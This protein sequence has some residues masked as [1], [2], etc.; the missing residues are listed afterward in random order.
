MGC[1]T[2]ATV[3]L[4]VLLLLLLLLVVVVVVVVVSVPPALHLTPRSCSA[5]HVQR[6]AHRRRP[7]LQPPSA[8]PP[9]GKQH[10]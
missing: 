1:M 2:W 4:Q 5:A 8:S 6:V 3:L 7:R 9:A 10:N